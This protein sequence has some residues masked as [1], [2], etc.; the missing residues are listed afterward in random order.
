MKIVT[1]DF[2]FKPIKK[3]FE[4]IIHRVRYIN[5]AEY[6]ED[7]DTLSGETQLDGVGYVNYKTSIG[8]RYSYTVIVE[9]ENKK[10]TATGNFFVSDKEL[11]ISGF[12]EGLQVIPAKDVFNEADELEFLIISAFKD[13]N[14]F[15]TLEQSKVYEYRII[16][17][18][19]NSAIIKFKTKLP[20]VAHISAGFYFDNQYLS[21]LKKICNSSE[22]TKTKH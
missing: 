6:Y 17:L 13:V 4:V 14:V 7:V 20:A 22:Q 2:S 10:L 16:K 9:D 21:A 11:K 18:D 1:T 19:G 15:V 12:R 3:K 5:F 8:G